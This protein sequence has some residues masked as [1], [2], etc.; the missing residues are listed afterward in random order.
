[1]RI[2]FSLGIVVLLAALN[3]VAQ[4]SNEFIE[5]NFQ[6]QE[7]QRYLNLMRLQKSTSLGQETF[8]VT[9]YKLD[10]KITTIPNYLNGSV[11]MTARSLVNG[12]SSITLDLM[13]T[14]KVDNVKI[15]NTTKAVIQ[16]RSNF[17]FSLDRSYNQGELFTV[18]VNYQGLPGS[19]G[20]GSF[21]FDKS[22]NGVYLVSTLSEPYGTKDWWPS[23]DHP[24]DKADSAD[25][26]VTCDASFK[27]GSQ[28]KLVSVVDNGNGTKTHKWSHRYPIATYLISMAMTNYAEFTHWFKYSANDSMPVLNYVFPEQLQSNPAMIT[29]GALTVGMLQIYSDLYGLYP[30]IKEKYGHAQFLWGG[31]MEHQTM[32][33]LSNLSESLVAHELAHQWFG[34]MITMSTWPDIWLNEGFATYSVALYYEKK[35]GFAN[36][37]SYMNSQMSSAR[38][39]TGSIYV[40][41][42]SS[43][44]RL[45][46]SSLVYAKGA[47]VLHMLRHIVGDAAF[48]TAIKRYATDPRFMYK[49]AQTSDFRSVFESVSAKNLKYFFDEWIYGTSFPSYKY[50][51]G[52]SVNPGGGYKVRVQLSQTRTPFFTMPVDLR[53]TGTGLDTTVTV[54]NDVQNQTAIFYLSK[55]PTATQFDPGNWILKD[56][57]TFVVNTERIGSVPKEFALHQNYPNPFNAGTMISFSLPHTAHVSLEIFDALGRKAKTLLK[58]EERAAGT[59]TLHYAADDNEGRGISSGVYY[60]RMTTDAGFSANQKLI[61]LR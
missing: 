29:Q 22:R 23:K 50:E 40:Q 54:M 26:W 55:Q 30:F 46:S 45:F 35:N 7:A 1:M 28:G 52:S 32:T 56:V 12:L 31:G 14:L 5:K 20:F 6:Q 15:G 37:T 60:C 11:T 10:I 59:H 9:Y 13:D 8:D 51:W 36:Y 44:N 16:A 61:I 41:D 4:E 3:V 48:F 42:T 19:S 43:V 38:S 33:S 2:V 53:F 17:T 57:Q 27:V 24:G 21:S 58:Q 39:A 25:I 18:T 47:T 34:D 49:V